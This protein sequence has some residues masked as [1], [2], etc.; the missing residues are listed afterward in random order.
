MK[1]EI[2]VFKEKTFLV[3]LSDSDAESELIDQLGSIGF[4]EDGKGPEV[5]GNI[6]LADGYGQ[7]YIRLEKA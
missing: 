3:L 1:V 4:D 6:C 2:R 7:H 5:K